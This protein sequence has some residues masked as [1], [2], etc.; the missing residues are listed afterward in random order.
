[1][2]DPVCSPDGEWLVF[3]DRSR[4][5]TVMRLA[6]A[7]GNAVKVVDTLAFA[8]SF[9]LSPDAHWLVAD[10]RQSTEPDEFDVWR[11]VDMTTGK[12]A[13]D[14]RPVPRG[15]RFPRFTPG[16]KAFA[17]VLHEQGVEKM[18]LQPLDGSA[19]HVM[20]TFRNVDSMEDFRF[21]PDGRSI[22]VIRKHT[23]QDVVLIRQIGD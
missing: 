6:L 17:Y 4:K 5:H 13:R 8:D 7:G 2:R 9:D 12:V 3:V 15:A 10:V 18:F 23:A 1:D 14:I 16:N 21:S 20:A 22:A 19:G 11:V